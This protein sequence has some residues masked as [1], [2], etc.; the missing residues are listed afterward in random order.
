MKRWVAGA[1]LL[2]L[3]ACPEVT[4]LP[5]TV[6]CTTEARVSVLVEVVDSDGADITAQVTYLA[7]TDTELPCD[8]ADGSYACGYELAGEIY[9]VARLEGYEGAWELVTVQ[10]DACHVITENLTL[11]LAEQ[12][13]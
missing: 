13:P 10:S 7:G 4:P 3:C 8:W 1:S 5:E 9:V 11:E 12:A 6:D 2:I